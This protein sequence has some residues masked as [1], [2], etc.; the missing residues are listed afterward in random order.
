MWLILNCFYMSDTHLLV[1]TFGDSGECWVL[2]TLMSYVAPFSVL[3]ADFWYVC[4]P[5]FSLSYTRPYTQLLP[6]SD[7]RQVF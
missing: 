3:Y 2:F 5:D 7:M 1:E 4:L 6:A